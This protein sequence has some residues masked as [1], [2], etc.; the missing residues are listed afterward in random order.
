MLPKYGASVRQLLKR[1]PLN[2]FLTVILLS[3]L[4]GF[5]VVV[6]GAT[7]QADQAGFAHWSGAH[8]QGYA[9]KLAPKINAGKSAS[10]QLGKYANHSILI[11]H[12]QGSGE[13]EVHETQSDVFIVQSGQAT[14][15]LGGEM[16]QGK[17]TAP[18]EVRGSSIKG[19]EKRKLIAGD[20]VHISAKVPHQLLLEPGKEFNYTIVKVDEPK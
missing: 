18:G 6:F 8:L 1:N 16:I 3:G 4:F 7:N 5:A 13:S 14:L 11:A 19:G 15:V 2:S 17:T 12:R 10:E 20:I 9:K